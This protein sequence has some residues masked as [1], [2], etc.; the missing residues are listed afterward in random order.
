MSDKLQQYMYKRPDSERWQ[1]RRPVPKHL[2]ASIG[3]P[4]I[5]ASLRTANH[6]EAAKLA[7]ALAAETDA[8][9]AE[10]EAKLNATRDG[11]GA[12]TP[13]ARVQAAFP[14]RPT[15]LERWMVPQLL[16]RYKAAMLALPDA[17]RPKT[18]AALRAERVEFEGER[19]AL[20]D[21]CALQDLAYAEDNVTNVLTTE[22][23]DLAQVTP[24]LRQYFTLQLMQTDLAVI[25]DQLAR[26]NG[27]AVLEPE[28]PA[29]PGE[30]DSW[31]HYLDYWVAERIPEAKSADETRSQV[32]R[33]RKFS[34][35]KAPAE[36]TAADLRDFAIYLERDEG[37]SKS[38]VKTIFAL[39]RAV[40][41]TNLES[42]LTALRSNP[43]RDVKITVP[44]KQR[45][46]RQPFELWH[47]RLLFET[48]VFKFG[49][50]PAK[51]GRDAAFWLP[52]LAAFGGEREEELGQLMVCDVETWNDRMFLRITNL[53][54]TQ[55]IK[56]AVSKRHVPVHGELLKI[57][58]GRYV[59]KMRSAG[60]ER[61]FP[62]LKPNKY[63]VF[64]H[65]FSTWFNEYL[66][67]QVVDDV[68]Y[69]F[70][71]F[72]HTFEEYGGRCGLSEYQIK[73]ILGHQP[74]GMSGRYGQTRGGR[75]VYDPMELATGMDRFKLEGVDLSHLYGTC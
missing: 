29:A 54:D 67:A 18:V 47:L 27:I 71:S 64:T 69:N 20:E 9:F 40:L 13:E 26:L 16:E 53:D 4:T 38:R 30:N 66:D 59:E 24:E 49:K 45:E 31:S 74:D 68:R 51:G 46:E 6:K 34:G 19:Q 7:R 62:D 70:H 52:L 11:L 65:Q 37:L 55:G 32:K 73:G 72:R 23:F 35:D 60:N 50:R 48:E 22:G 39:L 63:G 17:D 8:L 10:H 15:R 42:G 2:Q 5:T 75:R 56:N 61:L 33:L 57:G 28:M 21:A 3:K 41:Q 12:N 58:F 14:S 43:F 44:S 36:L 25:K 1:F